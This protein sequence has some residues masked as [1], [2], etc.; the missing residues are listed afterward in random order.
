LFGVGK[1]A[2]LCVDVKCPKSLFH[3]VLGAHEE[4]ES[5]RKFVFN[6]VDKQRY[7]TN[8]AELKHAIK[9]GYEVTAVHAV[10]HWRVENVSPAVTEECEENGRSLFGSYIKTF[11]ALKDQA[12]GWPKEVK[13]DEQKAKYLA[14]YAAHPLNNGQRLDPD[15]IEPN[16]GR[17]A[18]AKLCLNNLWGKLTQRDNMVQTRLF[19]GQ[20][21]AQFH[22]LVFSDHYE[23]S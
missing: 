22:E 1:L 7:W 6:L 16:P 3:P 11:M 12:S 5:G 13:T 15:K 4:T 14:D 18:V 17:K 20:Q 21:V 2:I 8:S 10:A 23:V 9:R 19:N